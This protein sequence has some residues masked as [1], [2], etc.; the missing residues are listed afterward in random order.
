MDTRPD[1]L[2]DPEVLRGA[3][4]DATAAMEELR[5]ERD[6]WKA[7]SEERD[8]ANREFRERFREQSRDLDM[9]CKAWE[10]EKNKRKA[11]EAAK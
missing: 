9:M 2:D 6:Y 7:Q 10:E 1:Y 3:L 4:A 8:A 5:K 11:L